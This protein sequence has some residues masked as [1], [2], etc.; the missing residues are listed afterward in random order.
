M[1]HFCRHPDEK[2]SVT[3]TCR[4]QRP[5]IAFA[6][7]IALQQALCTEPLLSNGRFITAYFAFVAKQ[8]IYMSQYLELKCPLK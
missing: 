3:A 7:A 1:S 4:E 5:S 6:T 8:Q 2:V